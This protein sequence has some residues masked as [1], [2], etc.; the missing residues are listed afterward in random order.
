[1]SPGSI[2][3]AD[4]REDATARVEAAIEASVRADSSLSSLLRAVHQVTNGVNGARESNE[5]LVRELEQLRA[6]LRSGNGAQTALNE[7]VERLRVER[8]EARRAIE[9]ARADAAQQRAF[10]IQEQDKFLKTLLDDHERAVAKL[11]RERDEAL[12]RSEELSWQKDATPSAAARP[13]QRTDPAMTKLTQER[14]RQIDLLRRLQAQ[15]DE[16]H[17]TVERLTAD[18]AHVPTNTMSAEEQEL[19]SRATDPP[20]GSPRPAPPVRRAHALPTARPPS[21]QRSAAA[22]D[23]PAPNLRLSPP[24]EEL[25]LALT[26]PG[27][28][29]D[30]VRA[31]G[32]APALGRYSVRPAPDP[33][34][35]PVSTKPPRR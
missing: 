24:P 7:E 5:Q 31:E 21:A 19:R 32:T 17:A 26:R 2:L 35:L 28:A 3:P 20:P 8:D 13:A 23:E 14:A 16:L 30:P 34:R 11:V 15:R 4:V 18:R 27:R 29:T 25:A 10:L 6:L 22:A 1:M 12:A 9:D 33:D